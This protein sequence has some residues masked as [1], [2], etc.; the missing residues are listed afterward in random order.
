MI[1]MDG[2]YSPGIPDQFHDQS[3]DRHASYSAVIENDPVAVV[4]CNIAK[5][6]PQ[7]P[8]IQKSGRIDK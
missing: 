5:A 2:I 7:M 3:T 4:E 8:C 1:T 6:E